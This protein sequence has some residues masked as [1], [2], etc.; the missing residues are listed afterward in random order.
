LHR[1][2]DG[3]DIARWEGWRTGETN[4]VD[5]I[6]VDGHRWTSVAG[7]AT[8]LREQCPIRRPEVYSN[9]WWRA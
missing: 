2:A 8:A 4:V 1:R 6:I 7:V 9:Y 3:G 5:W